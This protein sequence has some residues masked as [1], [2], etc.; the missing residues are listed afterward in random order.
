MSLR[1]I[2]SEKI[3]ALRETKSPADKWSDRLVKLIPAEALGLYGTGTALTKDV[4]H[5]LITLFI[6]GLIVTF[7]VRYFGTQNNL[8]RPQ[9]MMIAISLLSYCLWVFALPDGVRPFDLLDQSLIALIALIFATIVP[10][11]YKGN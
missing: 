4:E 11:I 7:L 3:D 10:I 2:S 1:I 9:W 5:G 8:N 6:G